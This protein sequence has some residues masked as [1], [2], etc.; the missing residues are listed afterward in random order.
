M[1]RIRPYTQ[2]ISAEGG[3]PS[4][5]ASGSDLGGGP[6]I[7]RFG[8]AIQVAGQDLSQAQAILNRDERLAQEKIDAQKKQASL[9]AIHQYA[10]ESLSQQQMDE[11]ERQKR[12]RPDGRG[13]AEEAINTGKQ[14]ID[15]AF[16]SVYSDPNSPIRH[17]DLPLLRY[18]LTKNANH[19]SHTASVFEATTGAKHE[20]NQFKSTLD[21]LSNQVQADPSLRAANIS[22]AHALVRSMGMVPDGDR[23]DLMKFA[24]E[25]VVGHALDGEIDGLIR[26]NPTVEAVQA[27]RDR[28]VDPE[29]IWSKQTNPQDYARAL[30][31]LN[32]LDAH[33]REQRDVVAMETLKE[34]MRER[35]SSVQN[36]LSPAEAAIEKDPAKRVLLE[37][38]ITQ[39]N[40]VGDAVQKIGNASFHDAVGMIQS[41]ETALKQPGSYDADHAKHAAMLSVYADFQ[42]TFQ[43]DQAGTA[44]R[45]ESVQLAYKNLD[46][47]NRESVDKYVTATKAEQQRINPFLPAQLLSGDQLGQIKSSLDG[48]ERSPQG[49]EQAQKILGAQYQLW[50]KHWPEV[51]R[52]LIDSKTLSEAQA[53]A[54][55]MINDPAKHSDMRVLLN[56]S[57]MKPKEI[58]DLLGTDNAS[59]KVSAVETAVNAELQP[60][61]QA[62]GGQSNG[63]AEMSRQFTT[64]KT[65]ALGYLLRD[66]GLDAT[67]A[68]RRAAETVLTKDFTFVGS[69]HVPRQVNADLVADGAN[70]ALL[71]LPASIIPPKDLS[72]LRGPDAA[73]AVQD[74]LRNKSTWVTNDD[75]SGLVLRWQNSNK[76]AVMMDIHGKQMPLSYTWQQL[77]QMGADR[78]SRSPVQ[79][80]QPTMQPQVQ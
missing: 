1:A 26:S 17:E 18:E 2:Q 80:P 67:S 12:A 24:T 49:A 66:T 16:D 23:P 25:K 56:T 8:N 59:R 45:N 19:I 5:Q 30:D 61:Y 27:M 32:T 43:R 10:A 73:K 22:R 6:G 15:Q 68:A 79:T 28:V 4:R 33:L 78:S 74:T 46:P 37:K 52:Q 31:R 55:R 64:V 54:S 60:F 62:M 76:D 36:G 69:Y 7:E 48:I 53:G 29:K 11:A 50:G 58:E 44:M 20:V 42:K 72:G 41:S 14:V 21:T 63:A 38:Q 13:H 3:I 35:T 77:E 51:Q 47:S 75:N 70:R 71:Q 65:L 39:A 40:L 57:L 34:R 9:L